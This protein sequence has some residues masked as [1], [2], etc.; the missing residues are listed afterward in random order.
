MNRQ[1]SAEVQELQHLLSATRSR[2]QELMRKF[3]SSAN[4]AANG[5]D[6]AFGQSFV[7]AGSVGNVASSKQQAPAQHAGQML[8]EAMQAQNERLSSSMRSLNGGGDKSSP[9]RIRGGGIHG[10][11][12]CAMAVSTL[13]Y[14]CIWRLNSEHILQT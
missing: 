14:F 12:N 2:L 11:I 13:L 3:S 10:N 7:A 1:H 9:R 8:H 5:Y 6:C 4:N